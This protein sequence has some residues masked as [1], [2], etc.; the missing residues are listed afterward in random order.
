MALTRRYKFTVV[1]MKCVTTTNIKLFN[2]GLITECVA[3]QDVNLMMVKIP[4]PK[5]R[6]VMYVAYNKT[7][8]KKVNEGV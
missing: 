5:G 1:I 4:L 8:G 6:Y 2:S 3:K 7:D